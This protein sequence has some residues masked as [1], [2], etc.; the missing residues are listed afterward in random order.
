MLTVWVS[1]YYPHAD[2]A[3]VLSYIDR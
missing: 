2:R 3:I 1:D